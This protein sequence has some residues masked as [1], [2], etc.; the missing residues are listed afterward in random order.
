MIVLTLE[1]N[2]SKKQTLGVTGVY[3]IFMG[4]LS[5]FIITYMIS[6]SRI[7]IE[8]ISFFLE[9][10]DSHNQMR[11]EILNLYKRLG[12]YRNVFQCFLSLLIINNKS[13]TTV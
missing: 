8:S 2:P 11:N 9:I 4:W 10:P 13:S 1:E 5:S 12:G 6:L 3:F 7:W